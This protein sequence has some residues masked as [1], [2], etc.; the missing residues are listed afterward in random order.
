MARSWKIPSANKSQLKKSFDMRNAPGKRPWQALFA[1]VAVGYLAGRVLGDV[2]P[3]P[4]ARARLA[5]MRDREPELVQKYLVTYLNDHLAGAV[6]AIELL[7][8]LEKSHAALEPSLAA[9][10]VDIESDRAEL[11]TLMHRLNVSERRARKVAGWLAE[12]AAQFKVRID[13]PG[14]GSLRLFEGL[15]LVSL[16]IEGKL[17][18]WRALTVAAEKSPALRL[19]DYEHL[20]NRAT[21]QRR[22]AE[23]LRLDAAR[24][25]LAA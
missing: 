25:A 7:H 24:A 18:L 22:R 13:D 8:A 20:A 3:T 16:G 6:T 14:A 11:G 12:K 5:R 2:I 15:E 17:G 4:R 19:A 1:S 21:D 10:R 9:L 23:A